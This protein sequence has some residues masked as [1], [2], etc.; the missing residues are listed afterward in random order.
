MIFSELFLRRTQELFPNQ[1]TVQE[2]GF[3]DFFFF[4]AIRQNYL[5]KASGTRT[6]LRLSRNLKN[7]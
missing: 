2:N 7:K 4:E 3:F 6:I 1:G 5:Q